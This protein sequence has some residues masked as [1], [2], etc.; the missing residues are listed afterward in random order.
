MRKHEFV[1]TVLSTTKSD[2]KQDTL[3]PKGFLTRK[4]ELERI[5]LDQV[6]S[7]LSEEQ[8]CACESLK[9]Q[10]EQ[11][12]PNKPTT[13]RFSMKFKRDCFLLSM[14]IGHPRPVALLLGISERAIKSWKRPLEHNLRANPHLYDLSFLTSV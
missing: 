9:V 12:N 6:T 11:L 8:L 2:H 7:V 14:K 5:T 3:L 10:L 1:A 13:I 4:R